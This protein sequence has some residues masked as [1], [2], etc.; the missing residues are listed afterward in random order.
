[1]SLY[2]SRRTDERGAV[3]RAASSG[4]LTWDSPQGPLTIGTDG[5]VTP[6]IR[7]I[8]KVE[9]GKMIPVPKWE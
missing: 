1:M 7:L 2:R 4:N 3:A 6:K 5:E 9:K 8:A